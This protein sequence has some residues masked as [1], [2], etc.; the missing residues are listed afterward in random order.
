MA[1]DPALTLAES[2]PLI[3]ALADHVLTAA[4][5]RPL[6]IKGVAFAQL[7]VRTE[8]PSSDVDVLVH[9]GDRGRAVAALRA[10]GWTKVSL[11]LP[12]YLDES[13]YSTTFFHPRYPSTIDLHHSFSGVLAPAEGFERMW[14]KRTTVN[15]A[16]Q[17]VLTTGVAHAV[18]IEGL[19]ELKDVR[20]HLWGA[21]A[22]HVAQ[23][24]ADL[25]LDVADVITAAEDLGA[26]HTAAPIIA[27]LGGPR[28]STPPPPGY[29]NWRVTAGR[30]YTFRVL[31]DALRKCPT[32]LP[33]IVWRLSTLN[34]ETAR[35]W[36]SGRQVTYVSRWR[37]MG[38]RLRR[39]AE[40]VMGKG[41]DG[42]R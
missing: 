23:A 5:V 4:G 22:Q 18:V 16:Y 37:V 24:M 39:A 2:V 9:P 21:T 13:A 33:A 1:D 40:P 34:D 11:D 15:V 20:P 35:L 36:A 10:A 8:R 42:N 26:R 27:V 29:R 12:R 25:G 19:N 14:V 30:S 38:E 41:R 3:T 32:Q 31:A 17:E 7:G 6:T 28:P